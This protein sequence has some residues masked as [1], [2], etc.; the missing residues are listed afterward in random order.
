MIDYFQGDLFALAMA[1]LLLPVSSFLLHAVIKAAPEKIVNVSSI[2]LSGISFLLA[3][4]LSSIILL[5][6][7]VHLQQQ[8]FTLGQGLTFNV[9]ILLNDL[10][11][12][13]LLVVTFVSFMVHIFSMG[14]MSGDSGYGRYFG[15]LGLFTFSMLGIVMAD[16]LLL[17]FV[18][19]EL[20]GFTSYLLIGFWY[21]KPAAVQASQKAF[22]VNRIGDLGF[23]V[24]IM[25]LWSEFGQL[26]FITLGQLSGDDAMWMD[27][28]GIGLLCGVMGK[29]A[30]FPLQVWLPDAMEGP[31]PVSALIH[32]ATMV[33]AGVF[34][35]A[36][37]FLLLSPTVLDVIA[38]V[39]GI[40]AFMGAIAAVSQHDIKKVLAYSTISQLGYM[41]MGI[42]VGATGGAVF[43]LVTHAFFKACLFLSAGAVIHWMHQLDHEADSQ[44][45]R[46]MGGLRKYLP[47]V[48]ITF[49]ISAMSLAGLPL[50]SGFLSKDAILTGVFQ[51]ALDSSNPLSLFIA[52]L[53]FG[54]VLLTAFYMTRQVMMVFMGESRS[55][56]VIAI[57]SNGSLPIS[58]RLP[59]VLLG[60]GGT[61]L[62]FSINPLN[63]SD[64]W[65]MTLFASEFEKHIAS[66]VHLM[67]SLVALFLSMLGIALGYLRFKN[68]PF[69][70]KNKGL[71]HYFNQLSFNNWFLDRIYQHVWV[72]SVLKIARLF[73][74]IEVQVVDRLVNYIGVGHI[75][76]GRIIGWGDRYVVDGM[77]HLTTS[78]VNKV[79][80]IAM[81]VQGDN[82]QRY[83][84]TAVISMMII[85]VT[86][87]FY[88]IN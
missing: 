1:V 80:R 77:V 63:G 70:E 30:Q 4:L 53:A 2:T 67:V 61:W 55:R 19:W 6:D 86:L 18:F 64:S 79:G 62:L 49:S 46:S 39:G 9:G 38:M 75:I 31:T 20:V 50:L 12:V 65:L 21:A 41:V 48:F 69:D 42:G 73:Q 57:E 26:D 87:V 88:L 28:A 74:F 83:I 27:I 15:L 34:L 24:A 45:M 32:A 35:L 51:W 85:A 82:A 78:G 60:I 71:E 56:M 81:S 25:I 13:M 84:L 54:A 52:V 58:M 68:R 23:V 37:I 11:A 59:L 72:D 10:T 14:Y 40:T 3:L 44:D 5:G 33:A 22:I 66:S 43:H 36:R 47:T 76:L 7:D 16:N 29:S 17:L 8:W